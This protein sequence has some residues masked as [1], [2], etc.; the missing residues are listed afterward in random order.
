MKM[1]VTLVG[2]DD[3]DVLQKGASP[4]ASSVVTAARPL[5]I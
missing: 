5:K 3:R 4:R 2:T 1:A